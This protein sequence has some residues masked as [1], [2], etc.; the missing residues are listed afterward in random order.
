MAF[1]EKS[2][3]LIVMGVGLC[4][5]ADTTWMKVC[6][7][8]WKGIPIE[9]A[10]VTLQKMNITIPT[11]YAGESFFYK[12]IAINAIKN[13][14]FQAGKSTNPKLN[15]RRLTFSIPKVPQKAIITLFDLS[16]KKVNTV[17][18]NTLVRGT[19]TINPFYGLRS[20]QAYI[21][22]VRIGNRA[23]A[24][25]VVYDAH[26]P[27]IG[28]VS[29]TRVDDGQGSVSLAKTTAVLHDTLIVSADNYAMERR[30]VD[31]GDGSQ[32]FYLHAPDSTHKQLDVSF[33]FNMVDDPRPSLLTVIWLEDTNKNRLQTLFVSK[34]LSEGGFRLGYV[35]PEALGPDSS[36]WGTARQTNQ[37]LVDA[38]T[39]P[40]PLYGKTAMNLPISINQNN[41]RCCI[42]THLSGPYQILYSA[43][44]NLQ[45]DSADAT[46]TVTYIPQ[47][48]DYIDVLSDVKFRV[49]R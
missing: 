24:F 29:M 34:W 4:S 10:S 22:H 44:M 37:P 31:S 30:A 2:L 32:Y 38:V 36:Y 21:L 26:H 6:V 43:L 28:T 42:E 17:F 27:C 3:F 33:N 46:G 20:S 18:N 9:N 12:E 49:H 48:P 41:V 47:K 19:Y 39:H 16:G 40:T 13:S 1:F 23:S 25:K 7:Y 45:S 15:A 11:D 5:A 8:D 35:C 14:P